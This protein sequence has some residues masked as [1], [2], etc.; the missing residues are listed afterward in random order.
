[1]EKSLI[2]F[3]NTALIP[4]II[5]FFVI[6]LLTFAVRYKPESS[7]SLFCRQWQTELG[8]RLLPEGQHETGG[9]LRP[10]QR[11]VLWSSSCPHWLHSQPIWRGVSE[12]PSECLWV[13][14]AVSSSCPPGSLLDMMACSLIFFLSQFIPR[15]PLLLHVWQNSRTNVLI[16]MWHMKRNVF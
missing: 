4:K 5:L 13:T 11:T 7:F 3:I 2:K 15:D 14:S 6:Y 10:L 1:M 16:V 8:Q 9:Q 12:T